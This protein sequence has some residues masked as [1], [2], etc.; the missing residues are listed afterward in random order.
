MKKTICTHVVLCGLLSS[1]LALVGMEQQ[2]MQQLTNSGNNSPRTE[3]TFREKLK[4]EVKDILDGIKAVEKE[5]YDVTN[6]LVED[7]VK[8]PELI[9]EWME[10]GG[11]E[12]NNAESI[13]KDRV[14]KYAVLVD[15]TQDTLH[16]AIQKLGESHD[17][18][19]SK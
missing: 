9:T 3:S 18:E 12:K 15:K 2:K 13:M 7:V 1:S 8:N 10:V 17:S 4:E 5:F 19:T 14:A 11:V 16:E 6:P